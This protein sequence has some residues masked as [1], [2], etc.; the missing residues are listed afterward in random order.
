MKNN[1]LVPLVIIACSVSLFIQVK[2]KNDPVPN[3]IKSILVTRSDKNPLI[4]S[5][6][7]SSLGNNINGP[8]VI[9]VPSW[10][11]NPLG[12]YYM[13]FAH[14]KGTYIRL[15]YADSL[16]GPWTIYEKGTLQLKQATSFTGHIASPDV[17]IDDQKKEIRMYFHG[18]VK[19]EKGKQKTGF[20]TSKDGLLFMASDIILGDCYFR[21]F[22]LN[23]YFYAIDRSG[24]LSRSKDGVTP[25]EVRSNIIKKIRHV[26]VLKRGDQLLAFYSRTGD[27]PE[28]IVVSSITLSN[29]WNE[30]NESNAI[31][32]IQ[33]EKEYEGIGFPNKPSQW[34]QATNVRELRD[35]Y[36]FEENGKTYLFYSIAGEM[37]IAMAE[38]KIEML[39]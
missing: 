32:V 33:P 2:S 7:S 1:F 26:A 8:S 34:G 15:A 22:Q 37:G 30:W 39:P 35:P 25:F 12:K 31:D 20:A 6:S 14:H 36:V 5:N 13:Y 23:D 17:L 19:Q 4:D 28:R 16:E 3:K 38:I 27:A 18:P 21:V 29:D 24:N 10:V 11:K 9:K